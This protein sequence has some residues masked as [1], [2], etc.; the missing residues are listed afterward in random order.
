MGWLS[1][2]HHCLNDLLFQ[3]WKLEANVSEDSLIQQRTDFKKPM[4][5]NKKSYFTGGLYCSTRIISG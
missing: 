3:C 5:F 2:Q 4:I 1:G